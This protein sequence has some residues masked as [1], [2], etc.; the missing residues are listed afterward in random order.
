MKIDE[1]ILAARIKGAA[2]TYKKYLIGKTFMFV[3]GDKKIEVIFKKDAFLHLTGVGTTLSAKDFFKKAERKTLRKG[4][5]YIDADHPAD[6]ADIKT[7]H[8]SRLYELTISSIFLYEDIVTMTATYSLGLANLEF[9]L[10]CGKNT[11]KNGIQTNEYIPY[12]FRIGDID[13][14]K[15]GDMHEVEYIFSKPT[16]QKKYSDISYSNHSNLKILT[17]EIIDTLEEQLII[18]NS[19]ADVLSLEEKIS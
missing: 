3:Y 16:S 19:I 11:D 10:C 14:S 15:F 9:T 12:S 17:Q 5:L 13:N 7:Q 18:K 4:E 8:L 2:Q 6:F 1:G